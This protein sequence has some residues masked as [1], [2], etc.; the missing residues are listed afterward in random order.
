MSLARV[1]RRVRF[2]AAHRLWSSQLD[3]A[4]N[5][6]TYGKCAREGGHGHN[7][8]VEVTVEGRVDDRTGLVVVRDQLDRVLEEYL[9]SRCDHRDL[10]RV[11]D[12]DRVSTGE[13]LARIFFDWVRPHVPPPAR[14]ARM[15]VY[16]TPRNVFDAFPQEG[17]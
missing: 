6:A 8:E 16:E 15:R 11:L 5:E 3:D 9:V 17:S 4:A 10:D 14:L 12:F 1:T 13:N 2:E 7:Y